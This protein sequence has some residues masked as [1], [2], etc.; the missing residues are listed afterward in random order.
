M[1]FLKTMVAAGLV[2]ASTTVAFA[3]DITGA[4][5]TF[6]F[7]I[8]SKWADAYKKETGNGLNYQ[9]IGSG[10]G[11]KQI[12]AK[13]VTFGATDAPLKAE[14]LEKD[15]LVQWPMVMGAIVPVVNIEGVKP[16]ELV[17][18]GETLANIY[19]GKITK[20]DDAAIKKLNPSA[21]L[22]S[23]AITV[24]RRSDGS[25]TTFN[26]TNY[27]SKASADWKSKVGEGTAVEWPVGVGAKG[28]E[29]VS[30]NISQTKN[31]IGYVEYAYAKQN[32]LTHTGLVNKAGKPVQPTVEAFQAA[33]SNADWSKAPG[34]YVIL[35]E[36][37]GEKSWPI[38]AATFILM[39]KSATDKAA[40]QEAIKFFRWAF[41]NGGKMAE[42][43]DY[44]PM[45]DSVVQQ[46]EKTWAAEIKS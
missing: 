28:N 25:G 12:Q 38:T 39:H 27:L 42:E 22:P 21:K 35:T 11:I 26:F 18:D 33:A 31:S 29:G 8:Y 44:I 16:G 15:G 13:T 14:Q 7:P 30:G 46:I 3:A 20:W 37:P 4:G 40:A 41:K 10:G 43:L 1:N 23:E 6:P 2:A 45:P 32:K 19:L 36:Q 34:Y 17:F 5:A 9:S 24:V